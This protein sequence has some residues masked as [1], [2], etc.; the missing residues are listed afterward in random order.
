M[1]DCIYI[2][3]SLPKN[4]IV[5]LPCPSHPWSGDCQPQLVTAAVIERCPIKPSAVFFEELA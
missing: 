5:S 4:A 1:F 2:E 3:I